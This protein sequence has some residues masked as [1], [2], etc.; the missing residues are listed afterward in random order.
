MPSTPP[1]ALALSI[2]INSQSTPSQTFSSQRLEVSASFTHHTTMKHLLF[3]FALIACGFA[4]AQITFQNELMESFGYAIEVYSSTEGKTVDHLSERTH[5][6]IR[7]M[8]P[9]DPDERKVFTLYKG[10]EITDVYEAKYNLQNELI[11]THE[12]IGFVQASGHPI[13][14]TKPFIACEASFTVSPNDMY[15]N[16]TTHSYSLSVVLPNSRE[17]ILNDDMR[18]S[19]MCLHPFS[20]EGRVFTL[21]MKSLFGAVQDTYIITTASTGKGCESTFVAN[22]YE[23]N[24]SKL[25][26]HEVGATVGY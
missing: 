20:G 11:L 6:S 14:K 15:K 12:G 18:G 9:F 4:S 2:A 10:E 26:V 7:L 21:T 22:Q 17:V 5:L 23:G 24:N 19:R 1:E 16:S 25:F 3:P 13:S 8:L